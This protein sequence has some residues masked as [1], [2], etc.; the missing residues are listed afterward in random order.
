MGLSINNDS[1]F[2]P[3]DNPANAQY[4]FRRTDVL[5]A[6]DVNTTLVGTTVFHQSFRLNKKLPLNLNHGYLLGSIE[7]PSGDHVFDIFTGSD[8]NSDDKA[9]LPTNNS[10]TIRVRDLTTKT[11]YSAPLKNGTLYNFAVAVDWKGNMLTVYASEG[12][13]D[14]KM[15]AGP[16]MND[17]K[18]VAAD[19]VLKG[20]WH[21]Q[22]IKFPLP[23]PAVDVSKRGDVPHVGLQEGTTEGAFYSRVFVEDGAGGVIT[24]SV[25]GH[26]HFGRK[27]HGSKCKPPVVPQRRR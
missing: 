3:G 22:L 16:V 18:V 13:D 9:P 25:T 8:F 10:A 24:T 11:L 15:V 4:G 27:K 21:F 14:L 6:I 2:T 5:P 12:N 17:P 7:I 20:E 1:I 19:N 26:G 23:D